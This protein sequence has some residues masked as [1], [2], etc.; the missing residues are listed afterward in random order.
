MKIQIT[1]SALLSLMLIPAT[2]APVA[3][4]EAKLEGNETIT[5]PYGEIVLQ[6]NFISNESTQRLFDAMDLQRAAQ[7]YIWATPLVSF[8]TWI[9]EQ[10][11]VYGPNERGTFAVFESFPEKAG[12][13]TANL[14]TPYIIGWDNLSKGP[15]VI[16]YPAGKTAGGMMDMWQRPIVDLGLTGPDKGK[17]GRY[18][19]VGPED[20]PAK[21]QQE[22]AHVYQSATNN[23]LIGLR[24][25]EEDPAFTE[26]FKK[27]LKIA[28]TKGDAATTKFITGRNKQWAATAHR[29]L[30]YWKALHR[31]I[32]QE[33]VREQDKAWMALIAP[34]GI[35]KGEPFAPN[36]RQQKLLKEGA[37]LGE[38]MTRNLQINPRYTEPYWTGTQWYKSF[39]FD[40]KQETETE[41]QIDPRA[42]WFY[43]AVTSTKG[44]VYPTPG[45]GQVYMTAK[46]D[47]SGATFQASKTYRLRVPPKVPV[48]QFWA[49]TLYSENTRRA[50][51]NGI[52]TLRSA[53]LDSRDKELKKNEDGSIDLFIGPSAP[54]GFESN[55]MKTV[56][57]NGWFVYFRLY[58]PLEAF[59]DKS[60]T[61]PDFEEVK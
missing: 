20:D 29:G 37:A 30:G 34:L 46:R 33:P 8:A 9:D 22:G 35:I 58:A 23:I 1:L 61:L 36:E 53:N 43:E 55:W 10:N 47:K 16:D 32:D 44:M 25:L 50:Y 57:D 15:I 5:T 12:I 24:I 38:L 3:L 48:G 26:T 51:E 11:K 60:F 49:L 54:A 4:S 39:D 40:L 31:I 28:S 45:T 42:T 18:I 14:T 56:G 13:L 21:Y 27:E 2:A 41:I 17:G 19:I 52:D 6:D 59:F 7:A